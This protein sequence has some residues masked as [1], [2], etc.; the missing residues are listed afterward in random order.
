MIVT[1]VHVFVKA[2]HIDD[3]IAVTKPNHHGSVSE[4]GNFRFDILQDE[5]DQP[6]CSY[7]L[8]VNRACCCAQANSTLSNLAKNSSGLDGSTSS[9][10]QVSHASS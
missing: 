6:L 7:S 4:K 1:C 2:E 3:F 10:S 9:G 8:R 5:A